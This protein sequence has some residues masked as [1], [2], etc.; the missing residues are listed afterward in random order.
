MLNSVAEFKRPSGHS[1][2]ATGAGCGRFP[3]AS[4]LAGLTDLF[5]DAAFI[6]RIA[7]STTGQTDIVIEFANATMLERIGLPAEA[8]P[9]PLDCLSTVLDNDSAIARLRT[10]LL[11]GEPFR[12]ATLIVPRNREPYEI[13]ME[14]TPLAAEPDGTRWVGLVSRRVSDEPADGFLRDAIET[15][16]DG[17]LLI[18]PDGRL[19]IA[20][21]RFRD[22]FPELAP[23]LRPGMPFDEILTKALELKLFPEAV[24]NEQAWLDERRARLFSPGESFEYRLSDG[25]W[26][27]LRETRTADGWTVSLRTDITAKKENER[28]LSESERRF[29]ILAESS[30]TGIFQTDLRGNL[31][32]ANPRLCI[33]SAMT[34]EELAGT[35]WHSCVHPD[36]LR[37]VLALL[38][39]GASIQERM[40]YEIRVRERW[41]S[42]LAAVLRDGD[43]HPV[44]II[45]SVTD[46]HERREIE[47]A[48]RRSEERYR[49][50]IE[51]AQEGILVTAPGGVIRFVNQRLAAML[52][53]TPERMIGR[54]MF[55]FVDAET[56]E[57]LHRKHFERAAGISD[58]YELKLTRRDGVT[59]WM[60]VSGAPV[61]NAEGEFD[62]TLGMVIDITERHE[63]NQALARHVADLEQSRRELEQL[64]KRY[65]AE[66][67]R[68]EESSLSKSRFLSSVS[69]ELRTPLNSI[70]GFSDILRDPKTGPADESLRGFANDI[71]AAGSYLLDLINDILDMSKIEAGKYELRIAHVQTE[72]LIRDTVRMLHRNAAELGIELHVELAEDLP[73]RFVADGRAIQQVLLNL[74]SNALKFTPVGG[75][76]ELRVRVAGPMLEMVVA[77]TGIGIE[78]KD[79]QRLGQPFEQID[80]ALNRRHQGTGLGLALSKSLVEMH[81]GTLTIASTPGQ[82]TTV[83]VILPLSG[84]QV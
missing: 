28:R 24:G 80:N 67:L 68:A 27:R 18:D 11:A 40:E 8:V 54:S 50:I 31:I 46:I 79:L 62:G 7:P 30:P 83:T 3:A 82:G 14:G 56:A 63:A 6:V 37:M 64:A 25:R 26:L 45:G 74:L 19:A 41:V 43:G 69:H 20:N 5:R 55:D 53:S 35:G 48:L 22:F 49:T 32:Y 75:R 52:D 38:G 51:T 17:F 77:D 34:A 33:L 13:E 16:S 61:T 42:V 65:E 59:R 71:H 47:A 44:G 66:K 58:L 78:A 70:L 2:E 84:P 73:E 15:I 21:R 23:L 36:D 76:V 39:T 9:G 4:L 60:L 57:I 81:G 12:I 29:R 10:L 1:T 72:R